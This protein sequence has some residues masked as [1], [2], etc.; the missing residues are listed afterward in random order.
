ML[1]ILCNSEKEAIKYEVLFGEAKAHIKAGGTVFDY[2]GG[3]LTT[4]EEL[5][6]AEGIRSEPRAKWYSRSA[7]EGEVSEATD[8]ELSGTAGDNAE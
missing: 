5:E 6:Y 4:V 1:Y 8:S 7:S 3:E 2:G